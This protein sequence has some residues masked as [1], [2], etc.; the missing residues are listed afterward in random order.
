M[1]VKEIGQPK[2]KDEITQLLSDN[3]LR[4]SRLHTTAAKACLYP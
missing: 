2:T 4:A 3:D 1:E